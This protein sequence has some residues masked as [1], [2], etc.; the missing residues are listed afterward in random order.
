MKLYVGSRDYCPEGYKTVD[1]DAHYHPDIVADICDL[2]CIK[3]GE[4]EA[5]TANAVLEHIEW[6]LSFKALSEFARILNRGGCYKSPSQ[7][8]S[9]YAS[10]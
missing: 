9:S 8:W 10:L 5:V 3:D 4:A 2:S 1:I 7:I 6:P